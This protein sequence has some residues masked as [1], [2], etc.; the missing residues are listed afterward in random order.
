VKVYT[1]SEARQRLAT[2]LD[3]VRREGAVRIR[4]RDGQEFIVRAAPAAAGSALDVEGL[5]LALDAAA[6]VRLVRESRRSSGRLVEQL[7]RAGP[8]GAGKARVAEPVR[9][10]APRRR[11]RG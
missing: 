3:Q 10:P 6:I 4:R 2:L 7:S 9:R 8:P 5:D 1:Y 11:R